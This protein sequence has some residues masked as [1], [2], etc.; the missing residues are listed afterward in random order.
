MLFQTSKRLLIGVSSPVGYFYARVNEKGRPAPI[1]ETPLSYCLLY[2]EI[3]F[4]SRALCTHN[5]EGVYFVHFVDEELE[6]G[7]LPKDTIRGTQTGPM[8]PFPWEAW[9][10]VID[11]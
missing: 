9:N 3:W 1:L 2:D 11:S 4:F 5:M 8:G 6:P 10:G 7:G